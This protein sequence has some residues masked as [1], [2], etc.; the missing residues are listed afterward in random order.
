VIFASLSWAIGSVYSRTAPL[1]KTPLLGSGMEMLVGGALLLVAS[2]VFGEWAGF[3]PGHVSLLS[4]VSFIYLISIRFPDSL[5]ILCLAADKD[6]D[7]ESLHLRVR[8]SS[9]CRL[10]WLLLASEQLRLRTLLASS[11][12]VIAVFCDYHLQIKTRFIAELIPCFS[13]KSSKTAFY[14]LTEKYE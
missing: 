4:L 6:D 10:P 9:R 1:P 12:I 5:L 7:C 13:N 3:Q 11:I 14:T 8:Q 2:L